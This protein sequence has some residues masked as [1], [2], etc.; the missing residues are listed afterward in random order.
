MKAATPFWPLLKNELMPGHFGG[1]GTAVFTLL[2]YWLGIGAFPIVVLFADSSAQGTMASVFDAGFLPIFTI[3]FLGFLSIWVTYAVVPTFG[4]LL[5]PEGSV[6][7]AVHVAAL[8][9]LFTRA[10]DRRV[11]FR[12]RATAFFIFALTPLFLDMAVSPLM[13]RVRFAPGNLTSTVAVHRQEEYLRAFPTSRPE[14]V[15]PGSPAGQPVPHGA[16]AYTGWVA[17][18]ATLALL[19]LQG[20]ACLISKRVKPNNWW[21]A[22]F[23]IMPVLLVILWLWLAGRGILGTPIRWYEDSFLLFSMHPL[24]MVLALAGL[25]VA[26]QGWCERRFSRMELL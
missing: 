11:L 5:A 9:F 16:I 25:A 14:A 6:P 7:G 24:A 17:W 15:P 18:S 12:A 13:P 4:D 2:G 21:T 3:L 10:V 20:Y 22:L 19:L 1:P 8:E 23:P 26:V